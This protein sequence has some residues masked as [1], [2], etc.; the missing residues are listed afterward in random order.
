MPAGI[1]LRPHADRSVGWSIVLP[2]PDRGELARR[3]PRCVAGVVLF[4]IGIGLTVRADL[5]LGPWDVLHQGISD[6][7]GIPMGTVGILVGIAI[8]VV[9]IPLR[10]RI[11]IGTVL[12]TLVVGLVLDV[13]LVWLPE[14]DGLALRWVFLLAGL[15]IVAVASGLYIGAGLGP[16]PRDGLMM[17]LQARGI[18]VRV[19][20]TVIELT[21]LAVGW[22]LGGTV[23][24]GTVVGALAIGPLVHI[25]LEH[26]SLPPLERCKA[27]GPVPTAT[28][29]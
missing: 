10:Q 6:R 3:L 8:L 14:I 27:T 29:G 13:M 9:W 23:G 1:D 11:G 20:R 12:N 5:G 22:A 17:G 25:A 7:T 4:G 18:S 15:V 2:M 24:I 28:Q 19:A 16:G 26:L 21:A